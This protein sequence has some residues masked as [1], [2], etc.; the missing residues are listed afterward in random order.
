MSVVLADLDHF[1]VINDT[2]GHACGD[3]ALRAVAD[4]LSTSLRG[5]DVV[6]RWGGEEFMILLPD[7]DKAGALHVAESTRSTI[8][9]VRVNH[10]GAPLGF[11]LSLGVTEHRADRTMEH[12]LA[13][14]DAALYQAKQ[15]GRNRVAVR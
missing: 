14:A 1:K 2:R 6:A 9:K 3:A 8:E 4:A 5:Q 7:T 12:T 15:E 10:G 13:D 11:T